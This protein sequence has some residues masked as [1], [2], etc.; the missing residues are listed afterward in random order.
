MQVTL[1][2]EWVRS[3]HADITLA[4]VLAGRPLQD[5][6]DVAGATEGTVTFHPE[7]GAPQLKQPRGAQFVTRMRAA[8][9]DTDLASQRLR[10]LCTSIADTVQRRVEILDRIKVPP[11]PL[12]ALPSCI[13]LETKLGS[14]LRS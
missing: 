4:E 6:E 5:G 11:V 2:R 13:C 9:S 8:L 3:A 10:A 14:P 1:L 7:T 12:L